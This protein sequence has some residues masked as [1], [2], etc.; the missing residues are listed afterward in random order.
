M[1]KIYGLNKRIFN[2]LIFF[3][4]WDKKGLVEAHVR[5]YMLYENQGAII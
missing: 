2:Y 4:T 5:I 1:G 3:S